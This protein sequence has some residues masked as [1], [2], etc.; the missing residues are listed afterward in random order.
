[1]STFYVLMHKSPG[2][3]ASYKGQRDTEEEAREWKEHEDVKI[4]EFD[5]PWTAAYDERQAT[6]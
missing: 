6:S 2:G 3:G 5:L 4:A 1:M